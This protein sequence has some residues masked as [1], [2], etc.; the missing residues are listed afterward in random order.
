MH[1]RHQVSTRGGFFGRK[2]VGEIEI[3]PQ[4]VKLSELI[5]RMSGI[6]G[7]FNPNMDPV[8]KI[9]EHDGPAQLFNGRRPESD[10][11]F[12]YLNTNLPDDARILLPDIFDQTGEYLKKIP[13]TI[14]LDKLANSTSDEDVIALIAELSKFLHPYYEVLQYQ[15]NTNAKSSETGFNSHT[16]ENHVKFVWERVWWLLKLLGADQS[17]IALAALNVFLHDIG[18]LID[19]ELHALFVYYMAQ[20]ISTEES[21]NLQLLLIPATAHDEKVVIPVIQELA[22]K[23]AGDKEF[24]RLVAQHFDSTHLSLLVADKL[25]IGW[26]RFVN[27]KSND[28]EKATKDPHFWVNLFCKSPEISIDKSN[29]VCYVDLDFSVYPDSEYLQALS[30]NF[31]KIIKRQNTRNGY[32][33]AG[34]PELFK[35]REENPD[36]SYFEL[37][38]VEIS[39][40]YH[41]RLMIVAMG[42]M[43]MFNAREVVFRYQDSDRFPSAKYHG[44]RINKSFTRKEVYEFMK[45]E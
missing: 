14:F 24:F 10:N 35:P 23:A 3:S 15:L 20:Q 39:K 28:Y 11:A 18:N 41:K 36:A 13:L 27:G 30:I 16:I 42:L 25:D 33:F 21:D 29:G 45:K 19:R 31:P 37:W 9:I 34:K 7:K 26:R 2:M 22:R 5:E 40:L 44:Q 6:G 4:A 32:K 8:K 12:E 1:N 38:Q 17:H 43:S